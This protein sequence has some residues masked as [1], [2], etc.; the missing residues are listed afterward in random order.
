MKSKSL[1]TTVGLVL[2]FTSR[3]VGAIV[4]VYPD[5]GATIFDFG[6]STGPFDWEAEGVCASSAPMLLGRLRRPAPSCDGGYLD[7]CARDR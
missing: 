1:Q 2:M 6:N 3:S 5:Q 4:R 7:S